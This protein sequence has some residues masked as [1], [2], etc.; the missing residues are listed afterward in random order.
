MLHSNQGF[1]KK[2]KPSNGRVVITKG[3]IAQCMAHSIEA[4][5]PML[6]SFEPCFDT[7]TVQ[8]Y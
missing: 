3:T 7:L 4:V 6:S 1:A 5:I 2:L 8:I